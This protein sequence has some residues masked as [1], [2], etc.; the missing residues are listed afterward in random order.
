LSSLVSTGDK[1]TITS[2]LIENT[3]GLT[4]NDVISQLIEAV[5]SK[6]LGNV[7]DILTNTLNG[8][9][10]TT[11]LVTQLTTA[12]SDKIADKPQ[13]LPLLDALI[14]VTKSPQPQLKLLSVL[15]IAATPKQSP[16]SVALATPIYEVSASIAELEQQAVKKQPAESAI[17]RVLTNETAQTSAKPKK[18]QKAKAQDFDWA[19]LVEYT[20]KNYIALFSVLSKCTPELDGHN[21]TL[22]TCN[23][24]YK[25]K[26]DDTKY[27]PLLMQCL[28]ENGVFGLN[29]HTIPTTIPPKDINAAAIAAI[30]GGGEEVSLEPA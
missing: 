12:I 28:E 5:E 18:E 21:L 7:V 22:Y 19:K 15:G 14:D 9:I 3:L 13:L 23:N 6:N 16:K 29:I 17:K 8:G 25:K 20:R 11:V 4:S 1:K 26:L 30:M 27:S 10:S 2:E 24:F